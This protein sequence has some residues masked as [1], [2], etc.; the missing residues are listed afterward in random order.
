MV[1]VSAKE[2][3]ESQAGAAVTPQEAQD[4]T[5]D[6]QVMRPNMDVPTTTFGIF[7]TCDRAT[8]PNLA[9]YYTSFRGDDTDHLG[10]VRPGGADASESDDWTADY[11]DIWNQKIGFSKP[12]L[13]DYNGFAQ[14]TRN[15][16]Y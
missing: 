3:S 8:L 2:K 12:H 4:S 16:I 14:Q 9:Q 10:L 11:C 1:N 5:A 7:V 13:P 15:E 6:D